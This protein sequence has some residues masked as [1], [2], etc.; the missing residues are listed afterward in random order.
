MQAENENESKLKTQRF[1]GLGSERG[2]LGKFGVDFGTLPHLWQ[3]CRE[4]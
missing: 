2:A 4:D 1:G 3:G